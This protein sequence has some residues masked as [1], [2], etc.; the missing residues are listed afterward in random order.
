[1]DLKFLKHATLIQELRE[2][3]EILNSKLIEYM[4]LASQN[5]SEKQIEDDLAFVEK[6]SVLGIDISKLEEEGLARPIRPLGMLASDDMIRMLLL[7]ANSVEGLIMQ[8]DPQSS[9]T[10]NFIV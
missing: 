6:S 1:M 7:Q 10:E 4:E 3:I 9:I 2:N 8:L 5:V